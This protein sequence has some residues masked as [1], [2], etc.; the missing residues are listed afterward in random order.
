MCHKCAVILRIL[1]SIADPENETRELNTE[2]SMNTEANWLDAR[3]SR[4][5]DFRSLPIHLIKMAAPT[6]DE[7]KELLLSCRYGD[8]EDVQQFITKFGQGAVS[9]IKDDNGNTVLHMTAANGHEGEHSVYKGV[10][11]GLTI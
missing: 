9:H 1:T 6:D 2:C 3:Y 8:L 5:I 11:S 4:S 7:E 10:P